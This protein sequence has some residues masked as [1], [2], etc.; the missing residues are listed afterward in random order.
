MKKFLPVI[1]GILILGGASVFLLAKNNEKPNN[2]SSQPGSTKS[3]APKVPDGYQTYQGKLV[4]FAYPGDW[5]V[6]Q[7]TTTTG[8]SIVEVQPS[9]SQP[10]P[11]IQLTEKLDLRGT[12]DVLL[13]AQA[14]AR[15]GTGVTNES[16]EKAKLE[17]AEQALRFTGKTTASGKSFDSAGLSVLTK[18]DGGAFLSLVMPV[19]EGQS[20]VN[21]II[22]SLRLNTN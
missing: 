12:F 22:D 10:K 18:Q 11:A 14:D 15:K 6:E 9:G 3:Y 2:T 16:T 5:K 13:K 4:S 21:K 1:V 20:E 19:E 17:G 7:R 8:T